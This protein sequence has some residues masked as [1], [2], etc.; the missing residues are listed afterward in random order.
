[1]PG[2]NGGE[3]EAA[4]EPEESAAG[5]RAGDRQRLPPDPCRHAPVAAQAGTCPAPAPPERGPRESPV[6]PL[7]GFVLRALTCEKYSQFLDAAVTLSISRRACY[8]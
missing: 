8:F 2:A 4:G 7:G 3:R 1:M 6:M 5:P